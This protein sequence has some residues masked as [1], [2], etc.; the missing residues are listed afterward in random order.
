ATF[1]ESAL[2]RDHAASKTPCGI[3][4]HLPMRRV[5]SGRSMALSTCVESLVRRRLTRQFS[6]FLDHPL[7]EV[8]HFRKRF[9]SR[10][11]HEEIG[12]ELWQG[13]LRIERNDQRAACQMR[14]R[15]NSIVER[16]PKTSDRRV[17]CQFGSVEQKRASPRPA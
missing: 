16:N 13:E 7:A 5:C 1:A 17:Q 12:T 3:S 11:A 14:P 6:R 4:L 2:A 15:I 10:Q 8:L 9:A